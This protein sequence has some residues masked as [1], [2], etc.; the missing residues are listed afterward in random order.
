MEIC[1]HLGEGNKQMHKTNI[2]KGF[3]KALDTG[4][5]YYEKNQMDK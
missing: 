2:W 5:T 1:L 4:Y 3:R